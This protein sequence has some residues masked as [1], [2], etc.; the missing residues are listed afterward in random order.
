MPKPSSGSVRIFYPRFSR[1]EVIERIQERLPLLAQSL[2]LQRVVLFGSYAK[3]NFTV[4]SDID[5]LV[6]YRGERNEQAYSLC[7]K[8]LGLP[9]LEPHPFS[10]AACLNNQEMIARMSEEGILLFP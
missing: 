7:K 5:L 3:G 8:I 4:A 9:G 10:E 1:E 6:V 2:P